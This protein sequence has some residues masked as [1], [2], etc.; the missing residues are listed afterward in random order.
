MTATVS[1]P[2][3]KKRDVPAL[4]SNGWIVLFYLGSILD[5]QTEVVSA[6]TVHIDKANLIE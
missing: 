3:K 4:E 6:I 1:A 2:K 5:P